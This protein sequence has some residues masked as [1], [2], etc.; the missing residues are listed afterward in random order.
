MLDPGLT[1]HENEDGSTER[2]GFSFL[3]TYL[4]PYRKLIGQLLLGLILS[5]VFSLIFPFLT[6]SVVD[7]GIQNQNIGFIYLVLLG[8][9]M[10]FFSQTVVSFIQ[11]W[12]LLHIGVRMN[13]SLINDFL[14]KLMQLPL[15]FFDTKMTGD[16]LQRIGDHKRI[17]SFLT[18]S[19]LSVILSIFN[20][21]IFGIVLLIYSNLFDISCF[22]CF[23]CGMDCLFS[24]KEKGDR[25]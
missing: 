13:V 22:L 10:L 8:Q 24:E 25:L 9:L 5:S 2:K 16:L 11:G 6:Q 18:Q 12:I 14:I 4:L 15:G 21:V 19:T 7:I 20:L 23:I 3:K 17:E 1:F